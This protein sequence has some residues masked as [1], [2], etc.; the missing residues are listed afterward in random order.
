MKFQIVTEERYGD[1]IRHLKNSF[2]ADEPLNKA[3]N[4]CR[5]GEGHLELERHSLTTLASQLSI[6]ATDDNNQV[7]G[8]ALNG[9]LKRG[10]VERAQGE[11]NLSN[12]ERFK[13]I[14]SFLYGANLKSKIFELG[15]DKLFEIRILSVDSNCRGQGLAKKLM[16]E[17]E[18]VARSNGYQ[19]MKADATGVISQ[20]IL[21][22]QGFKILY[23][24]RYNNGEEAEEENMASF[25][26]EPP[27]DALRIMYK[28]IRSD[29]IGP[30]VLGC[31]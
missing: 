17:S 27:H 30:S 14:F 15:V 4:L 31:R 23:E 2:F 13:K 22:Q 29:F 11:L 26:V 5:K 18:V 25:I 28:C 12:D 20:R 3:V 19:V 9:V 7:V 16:Q 24:V 10:D 6:M 21:A 8:V 1:V